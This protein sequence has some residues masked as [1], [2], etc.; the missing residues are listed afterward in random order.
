MNSRED[1]LKVKKILMI[2]T[3]ASEMLSIDKEE[4]FRFS[5]PDYTTGSMML[6]TIY[7]RQ[8]CCNVA[9]LV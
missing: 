4:E 2:G 6:Y 7:N 9:I 1:N 5:R 3:I 8:M